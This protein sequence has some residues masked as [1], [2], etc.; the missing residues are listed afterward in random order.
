MLW[1]EACALIQ[2]HVETEWTN[3][4]PGKAVVLQLL[5]AALRCSASFAPADACKR[6]EQAKL[7]LLV[8]RALLQQH[9]LEGTLSTA[10]ELLTLLDSLAAPEQ[11]STGSK[12]QDACLQ[13]SAAAL[14]AAA[15][16][17]DV[18]APFIQLSQAVCRK[19]G[20][21]PGQ[22][23]DSAYRL[24]FARIN[25]AQN[26]PTPLSPAEWEAAC[27]LLT[28]A[29][30]DKAR[31]VAMRVLQRIVK[32]ASTAALVQHAQGRNAV[33]PAELQHATLQ[34]AVAQLAEARSKDLLS[35]H[36]SLHGIPA[37]MLLA[38][39]LLWDACALDEERAASSVR[40]AA[41]TKLLQEFA[42]VADAEPCHL[43]TLQCVLAS[44]S[45]AL[46][47]IAS[48]ASAHGLT[49]AGE[50]LPFLEVLAASVQAGLR[51]SEPACQISTA[52]V[53]LDSLVALYRLWGAVS[54]AP[55]HQQQE[56]AILAYLQATAP[57]L[58]PCLAAL[59]TGQD[60]TTL[61]SALRCVPQH[62]TR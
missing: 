8:L 37:S 45:R 62:N 7:H 27:N 33:L 41:L 44:C 60:C 9:A 59:P 24:L 16:S 22:L 61:L 21:T 13:I 30:S 47:R 54:A 18:S 26:A 52:E 55:G 32:M 6:L 43:F 35:L 36:A 10:C 28:C 57:L 25:R 5:N 38:P 40:A 50:L 31:A 51:A 15:L 34:Q 29:R 1:G 4:V 14:S 2:C 12:M 39:A 53:L 42:E 20:S 56:S 49:T 17:D 3:S 46:E 58:W 23:W 48:K 19:G 11:D